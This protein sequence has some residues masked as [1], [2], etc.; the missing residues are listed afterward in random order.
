MIMSGDV[1]P[2]GEHKCSKCTKTITDD[3]YIQALNSDW[4]TR[5]FS[6]YFEKDGKLYCKQDYWKV[7]GE[8]CNKCSDIITG[9]VMVAGEHRYHPECFQCV[10]CNSFIG[11]GDTYALWKMLQQKNEA[12]V[13]RGLQK[14]KT[15]LHTAC[16]NSCYSGNLSPSRRRSK[17]PSPLP[18]SRQKSID[19]TRASSFRLQPQSHRV[20]RANDLIT[21]EILGRGF[22]GQAVKVTHKVTGEVMVLKEMFR[23][24][25]DA[26]KS[27]LKEVSV[28]RKY[29][30]GGTLKDLLHDS[31]KELPW[32]QRVKFTK[33][34]AAG[35]AYLH[36]MDIV[37][38][39]LNSQNCLVKE[40]L[41][42]VVADF[43]LARVIPDEVFRRPDIPWGS[44]KKGSGKK[45]FHRKK[46]YTVVGSPYWMAPEMMSGKKYDEKVDLFSY[47]I[48]MCEIIGRVFAD[49]DILPR[50]L[51]F[52]LNVEV[53]KSKYCG[54]CPD[55]FFKI[56]VMCCQMD[57][58]KRP[59]FEQVEMWCDS[60]LFHLEHG[61]ALPLDLQG[62]PVLF[63]QSEKEFFKIKNEIK[64]TQKGNPCTRSPSL[65]TIQEKSRD[66]RTG[67]AILDQVDAI[68]VPNK[69]SN[70]QDLPMSETK[71]EESD[72]KNSVIEQSS[73]NVT[74]TENIANDP[75]DK[76]ICTPT[77]S[78]SSEKTENIPKSILKKKSSF[79][80]LEK[81]V[82]EKDNLLCKEESML[83]SPESEIKSDLVSLECNKME[84]L[85]SNKGRNNEFLS[86]SDDENKV[87]EV[88]K[89]TSEFNMKSALIDHKENNV[90]SNDENNHKNLPDVNNQIIE[91]SP[92]LVKTSNMPVT[93]L[94]NNDDIQVNKIKTEPAVNDGNLQSQIN[95]DLNVKN[96]KLRTCSNPSSASKGELSGLDVSPVAM[97]LVSLNLT[98]S[99]SCNISHKTEMVKSPSTDKICLSSKCDKI[100]ISQGDS[101]VLSVMQKTDKEQFQNL[102]DNSLSNSKLYK[103]LSDDNDSVDH[104]NTKQQNIS[105]PSS[106]QELSD[107]KMKN[108]L[109]K[110]SLQT[111][112]KQLNNLMQHGSKQQK[113]V[114]SQSK[115]VLSRDQS[116]DSSSS[117]SHSRDQS[118]ESKSCDSLSWDQSCD[119]KSC[120]SFSRDQS[121]DN[122]SN[123]TVS[124]GHLVSSF[125]SILSALEFADASDSD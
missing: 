6:W 27:F 90:S 15:S 48:V 99:G 79:N 52:G 117:D 120:D 45:R 41:T 104:S 88:V 31:S 102:D 66:S 37:H 96:D 61:S 36:S 30:P 51:D 18:P 17:S 54:D 32:I 100:S 80:G 122:N 50:T 7:F 16:G 2:E 8:A 111:G 74:V 114:N 113:V 38:R 94:T 22:F 81:N 72:L 57:S 4:H 107:S 28:L 34:I 69:N 55:A 89:S 39:D 95:S 101:F 92:G 110:I 46:R 1:N 23:F 83:L 29:I 68:H 97:H 53:F 115:N 12:F 77:I 19:L 76:M 119:R 25:E 86:H 11:D 56:A 63:H 65:K 73:N 121:D 82:D 9:P 58:E 64:T 105:S 14:T 91:N 84:S 78:D 71:T 118:Y 43:G 62:D 70:E 40:D 106:G 103:R 47:G 125:D 21:G 93:M 75:S 20:F 24:D 13:D 98:D 10:N 124:R 59:K 33:D 49:P 3:S 60:L 67:S 44:K 109:S 26:Q 123:E 108:N 35:M 85:N 5:C 42:I 116:L 87:K 112:E